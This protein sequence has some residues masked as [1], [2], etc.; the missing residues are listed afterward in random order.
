M[1]KREPDEVEPLGRCE[2]VLA[3]QQ[4]GQTK[5]HE[6]CHTLLMES[7]WQREPGEVERACIEVFGTTDCTEARYYRAG[8]QR[9]RRDERERALRIAE[10]IAREHMSVAAQWVAAAIRGGDDE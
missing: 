10:Q 6:G 3:G 8:H 2:A 5:G 7:R 4:C 9:G 1:S